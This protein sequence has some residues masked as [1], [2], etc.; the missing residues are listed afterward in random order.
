MSEVIVIGGGAAGMMAAVWAARGG[1]QVT[2]L[3]KNEKLGKK[4]FITGKGRCNLTNA[5][6]T[7]ALFQNVVTNPKFLYSGFYGFDNRKVMDFFEGLH[8]PLKVERGNRVFPR[9]DHSSDVIK[10]LEQECRRLG[11]EI[12]LHTRVKRLLSEGGSVGG[13]LLEEDGVR[14][15]DGVLL[16]NDGVRGA[17]E[18]LSEDGSVGSVGGVLLEDGEALKAERVI[19]ATGGISYPRTGACGD[20]YAFAEACGHD[21]KKCYPSLVPFEVKEQ[22]CKNL[23]GLSLKNVSVRV[24]SGKKKVYEEFGEMLFTHFGVSGPIIIS[25]SAYVHKYLDKPLK[26]LIDLK[27]ALAMDKLDERILRDFE[28]NKNKQFQHALDRLLPKRLIPVVVELSGISGEK[29]VNAVTKQERAVFVETLKNLPLTVTGLR[30]YD[31]AIITKGGVS[32]KQINPSTME[33]KLVKGLYFAGEVLDLDALT[34]GFN[35]QIAWSTGYLAGVSCG[36][37]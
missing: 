15:A 11:V 27:P 35:L 2:L 33:S 22:W 24:M 9:S 8:L 10:A 16:E 12:R 23:M 37:A 5:C 30:G 20:G 7:E 31:E 32:V 6:D 14:G 28:E 25:A 29:K 34:G 17:G 3:E 4:L 36:R 26:L 18:A 19:V 13:A 21:I 1:S